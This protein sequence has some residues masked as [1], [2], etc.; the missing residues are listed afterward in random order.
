[1]KK[2]PKKYTRSPIP[3]K[4]L[5]DGELFFKNTL[6]TLL[7]TL[8]VA[9]SALLLSSLVL[10]FVPDPLSF[11]LPAGLLTATLSAVVGGYF[12]TR[13]YHLSPLGAGLIIGIFLTLLSLL[14][15]LLFVKNAEYYATGY[16]ATASALLHAGVVG[17]SIGGAFLGAR[18]RMPNKKRRR[19]RRA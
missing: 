6:G 19:K 8:A 13:I 10:C 16:S 17:L 7:L 18:E 3:S 5:G 9:G 15:S 14:F 4:N 11:V 2:A 1:M 12:A